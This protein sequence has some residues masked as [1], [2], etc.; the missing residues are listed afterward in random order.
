MKL[1]ISIMF[2]LVTISGFAIYE[3]ES[4]IRLE[5]HKHTDYHYP[6][7]CDDRPRMK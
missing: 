4:A 2:F 1:Y 6:R 7:D 3:R 5:H